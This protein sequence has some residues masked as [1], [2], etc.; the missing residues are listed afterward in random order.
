[1]RHVEFRRVLSGVVLRVALEL[2][3]AVLRAE[4]VDAALVLELEGLRVL[5][6]PVYNGAAVIFNYNTLGTVFGDKRVRQAMNYAID[7]E[8]IIKEL[9]AGS[10][11][12]TA[13]QTG[14]DGFGY[15]PNIRPYAYDPNRA[16][17]LLREAGF[18][19][20]FTVKADVLQ[21]SLVLTPGA[22]GAFGFLKEVGIEVEQNPLEVNVYVG[23]IFS[24]E[25]NPVWMMGATY[26]PALDADFNLLWFSNKIQ[27]PAAVML[28]WSGAKLPVQL[29][30]SVPTER[31]TVLLLVPSE[32]AFR[33]NTYEKPGW[34]AVRLSGDSNL[35]P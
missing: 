14:E 9:Y 10:G 20:G 3:Q 31:L 24:G 34:T 26:A 15:N 2:A 35:N 21:G 11:K 33:M 32:I 5:R 6:P 23:R 28:R 19:N 30:G 22:Q 13:Q 4:H 12:V 25:R 8:A 7:K 29:T 1:M 17:Q 16:R 18:P 27:P